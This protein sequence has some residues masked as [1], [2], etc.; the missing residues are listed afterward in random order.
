MR[1]GYAI[2]VAFSLDPNQFDDFNI[3]YVFYCLYL[4]VKDKKI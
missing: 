4:G 2:Y 3:T 1:K